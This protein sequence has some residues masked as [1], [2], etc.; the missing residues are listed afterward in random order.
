MAS[1]FTRRE[2]NSNPVAVG[3]EHSVDYFSLHRSQII[4]I[5]AAVVLLAILIG[6]FFL[7]RNHQQDVRRAK[8]GEAFTTQ[9]A[10]VGPLNAPIGLSFPTQEAKDQAVSKA[11]SAVAA[12]FPGT[13]EGSIAQFYV[14]S[15]QLKNNNLTEA[16]KNLQT[17][18]DSGD[19]EYASLAKMSL[20]QLDYSENKPAEGEKLL[21]DVIANPT[22]LVS[23]EEAT[24]T[25]A[26]HLGQTNPAQARA[27]LQPLLLAGGAIGQEANVAITELNGK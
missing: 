7:W 10:Y 21:R 18:A 17:L 25:L 23:K 20:A 6:G 22:E 16:R 26:R 1:E 15:A 12:E 11:F 14:A 5:V 19:K 4:K 13:H 27:L 9:D 2:L 8:L 3:V 24:I